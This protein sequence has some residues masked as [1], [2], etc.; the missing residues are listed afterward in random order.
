MITINL[1]NDEFDFLEEYAL[2]RYYFYDCVLNRPDSPWYDYG[3]TKDD[4][5]RARYTRLLN[6][7]KKISNRLKDHT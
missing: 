3:I 2:K 1:T 5:E 7:W 4:E 6:Y